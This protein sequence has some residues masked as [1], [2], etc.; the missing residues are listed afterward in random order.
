ML[1]G[2]CATKSV[3]LVNLSVFWAE[4]EAIHLAH[5]AAFEVNNKVCMVAAISPPLTAST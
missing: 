3:L 5:G 4:D 1:P 2:R